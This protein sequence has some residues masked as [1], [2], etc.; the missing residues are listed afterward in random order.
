[1]S[2]GMLIETFE[3]AQFL[4]DRRRCKIGGQEGCPY[5]GPISGESQRVDQC[6]PPK[7]REGQRSEIG[8]HFTPLETA[9]DETKPIVK[10]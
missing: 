6:R 4:T 2:V 9:T 1:M 5:D 7:C 8:K 10:M 3:L